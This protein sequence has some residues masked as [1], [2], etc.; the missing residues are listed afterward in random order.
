MITRVTVE[1]L[2]SALRIDPQAQLIDVREP[3]DFAHGFI[4]EAKNIPLAKLEQSGL[5]RDKPIFLVCKSGRLCDEAASKL[6]D[7]ADVRIVA[8]GMIA[9]EA[10]QLP[11]CWT[12]PD[13]QKALW[14]TGG[15]SAS[16]L[17][18][19]GVANMNAPM[20]LK[21]ALFL[22]IIVCGRSVLADV[23]SVHSR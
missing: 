19:W 3:V 14:V 21:F 15:L 16:L 23:C 1:N 11:V 17:L 10:Q 13:R 2:N 7:C 8:G 6:K 5:S 20:A 12:Y 4:R 22:I 9:W 18:A